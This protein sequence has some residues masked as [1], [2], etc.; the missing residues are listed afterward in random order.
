[1]PPSRVA[2]VRRID[3]AESPLS[4]ITPQRRHP[5]FLNDPIGPSQEQSA[6]LGQLAEPHSVR[7]ALQGRIGEFDLRLSLSPAE[8]TFTLPCGYLPEPPDVIVVKDQ[9]QEACHNQRG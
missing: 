3:Q 4:D 2:L 6:L 9:L 8:Q 5:D 1:V 7:H